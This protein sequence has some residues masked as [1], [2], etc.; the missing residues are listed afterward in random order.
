MEKLEVKLSS[1][2][3]IPDLNKYSVKIEMESLEKENTPERKISN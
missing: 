2:T 1:E 3:L